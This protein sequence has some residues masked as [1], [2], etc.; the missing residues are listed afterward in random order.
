M[1]KVTAWKTK[2]ASAYVAGDDVESWVKDTDS[3]VAKGFHPLMQGSGNATSYVRLAADATT[4]KGTFANGNAGTDTSITG[5]M[6]STRAR[7]QAGLWFADWY[8]AAYNN[9]WDNHVGR[10][11]DKAN[12]GDWSTNREIGK[13]ET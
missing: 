12:V 1:L 9:E 3:A 4:E 5:A 8:L 2:A 7:A 10:E 6:Q 13:A 11:T